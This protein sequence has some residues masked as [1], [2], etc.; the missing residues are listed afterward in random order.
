[1]ARSEAETTSEY[2]SWEMAQH[3]DMIIQH[4]AASRIAGLGTSPLYEIYVES[5][6]HIHV[7]YFVSMFAPGAGIV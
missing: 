7:F 2:E 3:P 5:L 1:M 6:A 4:H